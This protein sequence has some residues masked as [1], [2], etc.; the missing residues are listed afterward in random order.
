MLVHA[1]LVVWKV[2]KN[3]EC[4]LCRSISH[5]LHLDLSLIVLQGVT[6]APV[7]FILVVR[8]CIIWVLAF[9]VAFWSH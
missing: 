6:V 5:Q 2:L 3:S 7:G 9:P 1:W 4:P 8:Y